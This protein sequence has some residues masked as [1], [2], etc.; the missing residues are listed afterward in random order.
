MLFGLR[1]APATFQRAI[2]IILSKVKCHA[3]VY[4]DDII[5]HSKTVAE[6]FDLV[7]EMLTLLRAAGVALKLKKCNF[8]DDKVE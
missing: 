8:F 6:H 3:L 7:R 5:V 1:N 2:D 4:L